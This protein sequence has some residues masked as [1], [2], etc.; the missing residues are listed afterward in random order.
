MSDSLDIRGFEGG[1][2][3]G[4]AKACVA[5]KGAP[6]AVMQNACQKIFHSLMGHC[7]FAA[8]Q[9]GN[10][11][12]MAEMTQEIQMHRQRCLS[13][14]N[15]TGDFKNSR[16]ADAEVRKLDFTCIFRKDFAVSLHE[17]R[18]IC[19]HAL[20]RLHEG[21]IGFYLH[22]R[23]EQFGNGMPL[24]FQKVIAALRAAKLCAC[25]AATADDNGI[26]VEGFLLGKHLK[27]ALFAALQRRDLKGGA[28]LYA[29]FLQSK[30]QHIYHT[31]CLI[32][33]RIDLAAWLYG[34]NQPERLEKCKRFFGIKG[35]QGSLCKYCVLPMVIFH[36][37]LCVGEIA[38]TVA[39]CEK[40]ASNARLSFQNTNLCTLFSCGKCRHH[41]GGTTADNKNLHCVTFLFYG[42]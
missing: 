33:K 32:G 41:A 36:C 8:L 10:H 23:R 37:Q 12:L 11:L 15:D 26:G 14:G 29:H 27:A 2:G 35:L 20:E 40:L 6:Q 30:P 39:C 24:T 25:H 19:T 9:E 22:Q 28:H 38:A 17:D 5:Q 1:N 4:E 34:G 13:C 31:A 16:T 21:S 3:F 18:A 42:N 7:F